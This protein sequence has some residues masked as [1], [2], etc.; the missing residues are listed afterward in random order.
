[1]AGKSI[2][3]FDELRATDENQIDAILAEIPSDVE[4]LADDYLSGDEDDID[5]VD[6]N[7]SLQNRMASDVLPQAVKLDSDDEPLAR[8][9][10]REATS[11]HTF[12]PVVWSKHNFY[13]EP[14][15]FATPNEVNMDESIERP[16]DVFLC[17]FPNDL[18]D[19]IVYNTN[20]YA[21]QKKHK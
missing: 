16:L 15:P 10:Q 14:H 9:A 2:W 17:L 8:L 4:S 3:S 18:L 1:M 19:S 5:K 7:L 20:L 12:L 13:E 21:T 11:V 6:G